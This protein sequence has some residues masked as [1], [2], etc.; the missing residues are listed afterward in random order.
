MTT[1]I[2]KLFS[3]RAQFCNQLA[4]CEEMIQGT[5]VTK[6]LKCGKP[7]C[8]CTTG[9]P[10]GPKYY[11]S[12]KVEGHTRMLYVPTN[13][14]AVVRKQIQLYRQFKKIGAKISKINRAMLLQNKNQ[15]AKRRN[16]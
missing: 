16:G 3:R 9:S 4:S 13:A 15:S 5:L 8:R 6:Y 10:H 14:I 11:I 2:Q 7:G 1:N 12:D